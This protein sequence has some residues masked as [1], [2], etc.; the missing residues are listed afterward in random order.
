M[1]DDAKGKRQHSR[2]PVAMQVSYLSRGDLQ[3]DLVVNLSPGGLF[4]HTRKPLDIG[5]DVD[6]EVLIADE[7]TPIH[8]RGKVVW[9]RPEPGQQPGMGI[10]FTGVMG[11]LLL[12]MVAAARS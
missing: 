10:Q 5:T 12:E 2:I 3:K 6:L 9:L 4:V 1:T 7:E 11:P 8:V